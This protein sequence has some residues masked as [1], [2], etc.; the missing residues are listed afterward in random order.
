MAGNGGSKGETTIVVFVALAGLALPAALVKWPPLLDY[1]NHYARMWLLAG[2]ADTFPLSRMYQV[3]WEKASTNIG[4]DVI[5]AAL[6][7]VFPFGLIA[8]ALVIAAIVLPPL[9]AACLNRELFGGWHWWQVA[10]AIVAWNTTLAAGFLNFQ[11]G[12]GLALLGCSFEP[13]LAR[14]RWAGVAARACIGGVALFIHVMAFAF[15]VALVAAVTLGPELAPLRRAHSAAR[16]LRRAAIACL[17]ILVPLL[18][19]LVLAPKLPGSQASSRPAVLWQDPRKVGQALATAFATYR[20]GVD[21]VFA[22]AFALPVAVAATTRRI[23]THAGLLL[24]ACALAILSSFVP[25]EVGDTGWIDKRV[26]PMAVLTFAASVRPSNPSSIR[27]QRAVLAL[28]FLVAMARTAW[29]ARIWLARQADFASVE[30]ALDQVPPGSAV[31][32]LEHDLSARDRKTAPLG[33]FFSHDVPTYTHV[34]LLA[35]VERSSFV[36]TLFTAAG[37]QPVRV[38]PPWDEI[39]VAEGRVATVDRLADPEAI[40]EFP[41]LAHWRDRFDYVLVECAD[42][43]NEGG[44]LPLLGVREV[45][46]Q[47]FARLYRVEKPTE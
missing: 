20:L 13:A 14:T 5:A 18:L 24:L 3:A 22:C 44:P 43:P 6:G 39:A 9:G 1:P 34:S 29:V 35:I 7:H 4:I 26:P 23:E 11:I 15:Y 12:I 38:L 2:G 32:P 41:Y 28:T 46:D 40:R 33:R 19:F 17:P 30:R 21:A 37:K 8:H 25:R 16:G 47:G 10:F 27:W 45:S 31:L 36:P 42:I